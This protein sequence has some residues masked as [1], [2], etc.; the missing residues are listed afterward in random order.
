MILSDAYI[1]VVAICLYYVLQ[2][3]NDKLSSIW[4]LWPQIF[5]YVLR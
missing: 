3:E 2:E 1:L 5:E 4:L